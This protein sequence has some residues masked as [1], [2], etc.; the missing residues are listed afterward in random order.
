MLLLYMLC[1]YI[2]FIT[3]VFYLLAHKQNP[4]LAK[5]GMD[6]GDMLSGGHINIVFLLSFTPLL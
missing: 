5:P 1:F 3:F 4:L 2:N 6:F